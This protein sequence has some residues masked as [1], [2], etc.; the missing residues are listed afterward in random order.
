MGGGGRVGKGGFYHAVVIQK[1]VHFN[2]LLL[3]PKLSCDQLINNE[4]ISSSRNM[5]APYLISCRQLTK[6]V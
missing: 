2:C 6:G 4:T 1:I 5:E 3:M